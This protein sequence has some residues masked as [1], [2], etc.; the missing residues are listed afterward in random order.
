MKIG[1]SRKSEKIVFHL[2]RS[3]WGMDDIYAEF[4]SGAKLFERRKS[5][6]YWRKA[7]EGKNKAW[8]VT[9]YP[10]GCLPQLEADIDRIDERSGYFDGHNGYFDIFVTILTEVTSE[11]I[12]DK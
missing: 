8:F 4:K 1:S 11:T 10:K 7:L 6:P 12:E 5:T 2:K 3:G 9:G